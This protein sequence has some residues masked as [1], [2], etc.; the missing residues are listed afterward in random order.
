MKLWYE[1]WFNSKEYLSVYKHRDLEEAN[2]FAGLICS[3]I[4][5][6][7]NCETLDLACGAGRHSIAFAR[8]GHK[9]TGVDLS[10]MLIKLAR[11]EAL[12]ENIQVEYLERNIL[13][14]NLERKFDVVLNIFTSFGYFREDADNF[15]I[16]ETVG[17]HMEDSGTFVFDYFNSVV[18]ERTLVPYSRVISGTE[19]IEQIRTISNGFVTKKILIQSGGSIKM[20]SE[21]V[22]LYSAKTLIHQLESRGFTIEKLLADYE[23]NS[24]N[25]ETSP[26]FIALCRKS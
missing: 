6:P 23:G 1:E 20:F 4:E 9:V 19:I 3:L 22:K 5:V 17:N 13:G 16:F 15:R 12:E 21:A 18:V 25:E 26:R 10:P 24:F 7:L 11:E 2:S 14:L 8:R